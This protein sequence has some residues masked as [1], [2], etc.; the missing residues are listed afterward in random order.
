MGDP[1]AGRFN[2]DAAPSEG[3]NFMQG[4]LWIE[5]GLVDVQTVETGAEDGVL[6]KC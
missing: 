2:G 4:S 1:T 6:V 3:P 5:Y